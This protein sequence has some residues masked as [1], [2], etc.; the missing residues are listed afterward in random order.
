MTIAV[1]SFASGPSK[2]KKPPKAS[3]P[4]PEMEGYADWD[5]WSFMTESAT[6]SR[7]YV[8][9]MINDPGKFDFWLKVEE[10]K[11]PECTAATTSQKTNPF[12]ESPYEPLKRDAAKRAC[13]NALRDT[14]S[15]TVM[16]VVFACKTHKVKY[17]ESV[18]YNQL[19]SRLGPTKEKITG[20][21]FSLIRSW[22]PSLTASALGLYNAHQLSLK[23]RHLP[24]WVPDSAIL[25]INTAQTDQS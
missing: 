24:T 21:Q 15:S 7:Y 18:N 22:T 19:G 11:L 17:L 2:G 20:S 9:R 10:K 1:P 5:T 14:V 23:G 13:E 16:H 3:V 25:T 8:K 12:L 6:D 4:T